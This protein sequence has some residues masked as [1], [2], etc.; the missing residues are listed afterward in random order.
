MSHMRHVAYEFVMSHLNGSCHVWIRH[1][2]Y[3]CVVSHMDDSC[4]VL[5]Q[6]YRCIQRQRDTDT[7]TDTYVANI[8][9]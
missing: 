1:V 4:H 7:D 2:T 6:I 3:A 9:H 5:R 8:F